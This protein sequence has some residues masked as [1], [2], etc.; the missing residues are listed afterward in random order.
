[1]TAARDGRTLLLAD[2]REVRLAAIEVA[3]NSRDALFA[4]VGGRNVRL[5]QAGT[6]LDRYG[7]VIAFVYVEETDRSVQQSLV[8]E[9]LARAS[10]RIGNKACAEELL[11]A[12]QG[13]R[14]ARRGIWA[15]PNFA[16]LPSHDVPRITAARGQ[17]ALV[18]GR[19]LS[20]RESGSIIYVNF[21]RRWTRDFAFTVAKRHRR[22]FA[23]A[24]VDPKTL[25]GRRIRVRGWVEQRGG[26]FIEVTAPEQIEI[27]K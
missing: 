20:V 24:G 6:T 26:P 4:L 19:V 9:G 5:E 18:E 25:E 7:R 27:A 21:G 2:G 23:E 12:E 8:T 10:A 22:D 3:D 15:D 16:P 13:A 11:T 17:F 14:A 1:M